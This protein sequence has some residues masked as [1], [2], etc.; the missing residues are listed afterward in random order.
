[1]K[2]DVTLILNFIPKIDNTH[3]D[4]VDFPCYLAAQI[5][6]SILMAGNPSADT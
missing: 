1:M 6:I 4:I 5:S 2:K 3:L